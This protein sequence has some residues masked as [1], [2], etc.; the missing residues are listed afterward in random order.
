MIRWSSNS[1]NSE[2]EKDEHWA[3]IRSHYLLLEQQIGINK[4]LVSAKQKSFTHGLPMRHREQ[5]KF[6]FCLHKCQ[7]MNLDGNHF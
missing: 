1:Q 7:P 4:L 2:T 5:R 6:S 3:K